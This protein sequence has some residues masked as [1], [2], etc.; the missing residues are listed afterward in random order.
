MTSSELGISE[1]WISN[2]EYKKLYWL[3]RQLSQA[4]PYAPCESLKQKQL[5]SDPWALS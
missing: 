1:I 3:A 4:F 5:A 2:T